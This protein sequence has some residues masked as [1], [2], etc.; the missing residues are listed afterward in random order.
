MIKHWL[1]G[2]EFGYSVMTL[3]LIWAQPL[4]EKTA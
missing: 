4:I 3:E 1:A 2:G